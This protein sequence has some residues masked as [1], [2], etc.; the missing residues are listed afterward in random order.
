MYRNN[1]QG[2]PSPQ[3]TSPMMNRS[4][5]TPS[6]GLM[7][8]SSAESQTQMSNVY[9]QSV[10]NL[11]NNFNLSAN[12]GSNQVQSNCNKILNA[13][14]LFYSDSMNNGNNNNNMSVFS[15]QEQTQY[16]A[17]NVYVN[18]TSGGSFT[19]IHTNENTSN[20]NMNII[21]AQ[22]Q[23]QSAN[24]SSNLQQVQD[25][26]NICNQSQEPNITVE[27]SLL[28]LSQLDDLIPLQNS[29]ELR[30]SNLSIST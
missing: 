29:E 17:P 13:N 26:Y 1:Y 22:K 2:S 6:P 18:R 3:P 15:S 10:M 16:I 27:S 9:N 7:R 5:T 21:V 11:E 8:N 19:P 4:M 12:I 23:C 14:D 20:S 28:H 24:I 30:M 25:V